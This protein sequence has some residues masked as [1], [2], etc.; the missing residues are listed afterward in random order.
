MTVAYLVNQYPQTSQSFIRREIA[1]LEAAGINVRRYSLR[2]FTGKLAD[3]ADEAE[4]SKTRVVL[5]VGP[6]QLAMVMLESLFTRPAR[7]FAALRLTI[8]AGNKSDRGLLRHFAYLA[9]ACV[10][11]KWVC[12]A[13]HLHA[14]FGTNSA[15]VAML[16]RELGG[17]PFSFT[18]HGPEEFDAL[19][20][21]SLPDKIE[22]AKFVVA[23]SSFGKAQLCRCCPP[24]SWHKIQ[25]VRCGVDE[26]FLHPTEPVSPPSDQS[27]QFAC[28]GRFE[29]QKGHLQLLEAIAQVAAA[30]KQFQVV[31]VGDGSMRPL[32][33]Q[34]IA[35]LKIAGHVRLAGWL[36][37][38]RVRDEILAS[39]ALILASF[40]EGL[41]VVIMESLALGRPVIAS[42]VAGIPELVEPEKSGWL[43][44]ALASAML[45]ALSADTEKLAE[46]GNHGR[47]RVLENHDSAKEAARLAVLFSAG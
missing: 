24:K 8:R 22:R 14:H 35:E 4:R 46:M 10:L 47:R 6:L 32:I 11:R 17:P 9:E 13:D 7:F 37:G 43:V 33:E 44:P 5:D 3:P 40:A 12:D 38:A 27:R 31:L 23:I 15:T 2:R 28:I 41:P 19:E 25:I 30:G 20:G 45:Q 29:S 21:L 42:C 34:R 36:S 16:C 26:S 39:R 1:A 18:A